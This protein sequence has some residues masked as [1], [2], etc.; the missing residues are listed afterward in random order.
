MFLFDGPRRVDR[1]KTYCDYR[2][3]QVIVG[4]ISN[5][6]RYKCHFHSDAS[7]YCYKKRKPAC[8]GNDM[9]NN[10]IILST[11]RGVSFRRRVYVWT[12]W[13]GQQP[14]G[15]ESLILSRCFSDPNQSRHAVISYPPIIHLPSQPPAGV[16]SSRRTTRA[17]TRWARNART[18]GRRSRRTRCR[19]RKTTPSSWSPRWVC[20]TAWPSSLAASSGPA[21]S[22]R[23][24]ACWRTPDRWTPRLSSGSCP[25][26]F[27][28]YYNIILLCC[29]T[30]NTHTH[31]WL[32][33][34]GDILWSYILM[35]LHDYDPSTRVQQ[36]LRKIFLIFS[37]FKHFT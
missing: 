13:S 8:V 20:W 5:E 21:Y 1:G 19:L 30:Y 33:I 18:T 14:T 31:T 34:P 9:A 17:R 24:R 11:A 16:W 22:F 4:S 15:V 26:S 29:V 27:Q 6:N 35:F 3:S 36:Y 28:W 7:S 10:N 12:L 37:F 23:R 2:L 25:A 32:Q